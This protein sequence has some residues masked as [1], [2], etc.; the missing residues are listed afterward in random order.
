MNCYAAG[1]CNDIVSVVEERKMFPFVGHCFVDIRY[2]QATPSLCTQQQQT[3][4]CNGNT[5]VS[6]L[7]IADVFVAVVVVA[8][9]W[10][11]QFSTR[12]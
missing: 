6:D 5:T 4:K 10:F 2:A 8:V 1:S 11:V 12:R 7:V 9:G 3:T